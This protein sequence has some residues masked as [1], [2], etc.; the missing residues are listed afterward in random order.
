MNDGRK[1]ILGDFV[2]STV[3]GCA[4]F[5]GLIFITVMIGTSLAIL[6]SIIK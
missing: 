4:T 1:N 2:M 6:I 5:L 3:I